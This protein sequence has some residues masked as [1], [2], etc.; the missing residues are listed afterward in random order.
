MQTMPAPLDALEASSG[1]GEFLVGSQA[2]IVA[3]LKN[4]ADGDV[5]LNL[6]SPRGAH[7]SSTVWA[8]DAARGTLSLTAE[9]N[10]VQ[11]QN[12]L[13]DGEVVAVGYLEAVKLQFDLTDLMLVRGVGGCVMSARLPRRMYRF[14]RRSSFRVKPMG[15]AS[16]VA[17]L[18]H[19]AVADMR[20]ALRVLDVSISGVALFL[21]EDTP[22]IEPGTT[23]GLAQ[24]ELDGDT[25]FGASLV[26]HHVT[27][28]NHESKGGRLGCE[29]AKVEPGGERQLQRY[30]DQTQKRRRLLTL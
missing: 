18:R 4:C 2:E 20:L 9:P 10:D 30:I 6:S 3:L 23:I 12:L 16:P 22:P 14:Q 17:V 5:V 27:L 8:V 29:F 25:R 21:P 11:L 1:L 19:P 15:N 24:I 7:Y 28:L 26:V 13:E